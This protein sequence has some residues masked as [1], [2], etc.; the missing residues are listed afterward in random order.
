MPGIRWAAVLACLALPAALPAQELTPGTEY[1]LDA[2][3]SEIAWE[4][5]ASLRGVRSRTHE[6][7]GSARVLEA[8]EDG[9]RLEGRLEIDAASFET[10]S[11]RR[12][13]TLRE[14]SLSAREHPRIV[15]SPRRIFRISSWA[16]DE[17]FAIEGELEIRGVTQP[18]SIPVTLTRRGQRL[19]VEGTAR[20][21]W[22]DYGVPDPSSFLYRV[23]PEVQVTAHLELVPHP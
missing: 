7:S 21:Y 8:G 13:R 2:G 5:P 4:L 1:R 3:K 20:L 6:L 22:A 10:G 12:D 17:A 9:V 14:E 19:V 16:E 11:A 18:V 23:R 15:F